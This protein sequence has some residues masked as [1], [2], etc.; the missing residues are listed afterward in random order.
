MQLAGFATFN[1]AIMVLA[2]GKLLTR[3]VRLL[4]DFSIPEPVSSG[5]L[6]RLLVARQQRLTGLRCAGCWPAPRRR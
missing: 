2:A 1:V 6:V 5:L 3:R 4:S